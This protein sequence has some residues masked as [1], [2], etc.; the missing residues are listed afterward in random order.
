MLNAYLNRNYH[1]N[2]KSQI[3]TTIYYQLSINEKLDNNNPDF[4]E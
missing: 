3:A 2:K 1:D 4:N